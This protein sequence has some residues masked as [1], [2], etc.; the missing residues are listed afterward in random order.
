[1]CSIYDISGMV[2]EKNKPLLA[3]INLSV[4]IT[5]VNVSTLYMY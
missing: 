4:P 3:Q 1:M 5:L 2:Q